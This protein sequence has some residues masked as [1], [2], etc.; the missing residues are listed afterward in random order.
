M[1]LYELKNI[2]D[3][4][5]F[6]YRINCAKLVVGIVS[7]Y[8]ISY[9]QMNEKDIK[10]YPKIRDYY[11]NE[12]I[13]TED[14]LHIFARNMELGSLMK[15][16]PSVTR[17]EFNASEWNEFLQVN[18]WEC[19]G[20]RNRYQFNNIT[21]ESKCLFLKQYRNENGTYILSYVRND[22]EYLFV[23]W[24]NEYIQLVNPIPYF[25]LQKKS[26]ENEEKDIYFDITEEQ[27]FN[28][29]KTLQELDEEQRKAVRADTEK[30]L[31]ILAGAG[32]GKT[33]T[34]LCRYAYLHVMKNIPLRKLLLITFT[35]EAASKLRGDG[36]KLLKEIY[37]IYKPDEVPA[38]EVSTIDALLKR[39]LDANWAYLGFSTAPVLKVGNHYEYEYYSIIER[40]IEENGLMNHYKRYK[41]TNYVFKNMEA[42]LSG[43]QGHV[44]DYDLLIQLFIEY[45]KKNNRIYNFIYINEI[46]RTAMSEQDSWLKALFMHTYDAVLID[47]FQDI[48]RL[49]NATFQ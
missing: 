11:L 40:L 21:F 45:Q 46:I 28:S 34:L 8:A 20:T 22:E 49:Q 25:I 10:V 33:R 6:S 44:I 38:M 14:L 36:T 13:S 32:S 5:E 26:I 7:E 9:L 48:N 1:Q 15:G 30:N 31:V 4:E 18:T 3:E 24:G 39:T 37:S 42:Y 43:V 16:F 47:E 23:S 35:N 12:E 29:S 41:G 17:E 19:D 27:F 2:R